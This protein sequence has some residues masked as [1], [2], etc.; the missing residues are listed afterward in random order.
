MKIKISVID[1]EG[2]SEYGE[3]W[4]EYS[5]QLAE[6]NPNLNEVNDPF[7]NIVLVKTIEIG[8]MPVSLKQKFLDT[9]QQHLNDRYLKFLP[10]S[11]ISIIHQ[12]KNNI[13]YSNDKL[14]H[15]YTYGAVQ[16]LFTNLNCV[17]DPA[18]RVSQF[19]TVEEGKILA[20]S[21]KQSQ[22]SSHEE[23]QRCLATLK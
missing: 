1:N 13:I 23:V 14:S 8:N 12:I 18:R 7:S 21:S 6:V 19:L 16:G 17:K 22:L 2:A 3:S 4:N 15:A 20:A 11:F 10:E 9:L 5:Y